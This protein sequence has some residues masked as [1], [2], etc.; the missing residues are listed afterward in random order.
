MAELWDTAAGLQPARH[1]TEQPESGTKSV[2][3]WDLQGNAFVGIDP[4]TSDGVAQTPH[5]PPAPLLTFCPRSCPISPISCNLLNCHWG[6]KHPLTWLRVTKHSLQLTVRRTAAKTA[7]RKLKFWVLK[8][9]HQPLSHN[10]TPIPAEDAITRNTPARDLAAAPSP[11]HTRCPPPTLPRC[12]AHA[13]WLQPRSAGLPASWS[14]PFQ[15]TR[16]IQHSHAS[17]MQR[18][19]SIQPLPARPFVSSPATYANDSDRQ[20]A[21]CIGA[22]F[23]IFASS[24]LNDA[25]ITLKGLP[26]HFSV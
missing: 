6:S 7:I 19:G 17:R 21:A 14:Q 3:F 2:Q 16:H 18:N 9:R 10:L 1:P 8:C 25:R 15:R 11:D 20:E 5:I 22:K 24:H 12:T 4:P 26:W 23:Y 13:M